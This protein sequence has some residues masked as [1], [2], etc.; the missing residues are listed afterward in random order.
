M[1]ATVDAYTV[2]K[3]FHVLFAIVWIGG[4]LTITILAELIRRAHQPGELASFARRVE[5]VSMRVFVPSSLIVVGLGFYLVSKG[6]WGYKFWI[7][8]SLVAYGVSFVTGAAFL[9]P[10]SGQIAKLAA[11][12]GPDA[13]ATLAKINLV[14]NTA[15]LDLLLLVSIVFMMVTK[16]GQ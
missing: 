15:R 8:Y 10:Q 12:E 11:S 16:V 7:V 2:A 4:G 5:L 9:G 1:L 14:I 6:D 13:P 3:F